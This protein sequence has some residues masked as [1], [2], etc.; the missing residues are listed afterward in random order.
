[1]HELAAKDA[2]GPLWHRPAFDCFICP[3]LSFVFPE[4][5]SLLLVFLLDWLVA[6]CGYTVPHLFTEYRETL[7]GKPGVPAVLVPCKKLVSQ[8]KAAFPGP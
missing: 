5:Y 2:G 8:F 6:V 3:L 4:F 1:M 7:P